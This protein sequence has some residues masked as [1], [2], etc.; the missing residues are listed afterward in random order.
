MTK[1][2]CTVLE[3]RKLVKEDRNVIFAPVLRKSPA[4][5]EGLAQPPVYR[6]PSTVLKVST[7]QGYGRTALFI[8]VSWLLSHGLP[9]FRRN[10]AV[11]LTFE[12]IRQLP[13][14]SL[15]KFR[16]RYRP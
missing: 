1:L 14:C 13:Q 12:L 5:P 7:R 16:G 8:P 3:R 6:A 10:D 15:A 9:P 11:I 2:S 4:R